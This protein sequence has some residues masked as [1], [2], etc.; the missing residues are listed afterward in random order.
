MAQAK[1]KAIVAL[2]ENDVQ[3]QRI[4]TIQTLGADGALHDMYRISYMVREHGPFFLETP[5]EG[6]S[7]EDTRLRINDRATEL[8]MLIGS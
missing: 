6:F 3:V 2:Q 7:S 5:V 4:V 1:P 8:L